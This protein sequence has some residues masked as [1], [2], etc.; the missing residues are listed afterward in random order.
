MKKIS[1]YNFNACVQMM[2]PLRP[3]SESIEV[4]NSR[5]NYLIIG[6]LGHKY[7]LCLKDGLL[8]FT[9]HN[10]CAQYTCFY[11]MKDVFIYYLTS[12]HQ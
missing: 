6:T 12:L 2:K 10:I 3:E 4:E 5:T 8:G 1:V 9:L 7:S 11:I